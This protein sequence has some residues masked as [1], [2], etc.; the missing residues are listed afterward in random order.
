MKFRKI[1]SFED[2][3]MIAEHARLFVVPGI[4]VY[5]FVSWRFRIFAVKYLSTS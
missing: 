5:V 2:K 4:I 3:I 1:K